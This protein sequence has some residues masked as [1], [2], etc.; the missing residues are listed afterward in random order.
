MS[1]NYAII[2]QFVIPQTMFYQSGVQDIFVTLWRFHNH[3]WQL[4]HHDRLSET[5]GT[6]WIHQ[7]ALTIQRCS[8]ATGCGINLLSTEHADWPKQHDMFKACDV[9][10]GHRH[11]CS[12]LNCFLS[13][14][15][16]GVVACIE[17][18]CAIKEKNV[19][20]ACRF[21]L[22]ALKKLHSCWSAHTIFPV[23]LKQINMVAIKT[24]FTES[25]FHWVLTFTTSH[26]SQTSFSV[27]PTNKLLS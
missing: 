25:K 5:S 18:R 7:G 26:S 21:G 9:T 27:S 2:T 23:Q 15:I 3:T 4:Q 1:K 20:P 17:S 16:H 22:I 14:F 8:L 13:T 6:L 10:N 19:L 11:L 24:C 12:L